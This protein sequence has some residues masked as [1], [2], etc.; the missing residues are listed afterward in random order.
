MR[1]TLR[2]PASL[3]NHAYD[4]L[5]YS[6]YLAAKSSPCYCPGLSTIEIVITSMLD[7]INPFK[8]KEKVRY[9]P[10]LE[11]IDPNESHLIDQKA[12]HI[13]DLIQKNFEKHSHAYRRTHLKTQGLVTGS[14]TVH[15]DLPEDLHTSLFRPGEKYNVIMRYANEP[16]KID[17]D[18]VPGPRGIGMKIFLDRETTQDIL[19]NNGPILE[20]TDVKTRKEIFEFE[21]K[22]F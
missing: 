16:F 21:G 14:L 3:C 17:P 6:L 2:T 18:T 4:V 9:T 8:E 11:I 19:M 5:H 20:L 1:S 15:S 13:K 7:P 22:V 10:D 12:K